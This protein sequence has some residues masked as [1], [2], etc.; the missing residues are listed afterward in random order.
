[1]SANQLRVSGR[2]TALEV[3]G[4][5]LSLSGTGLSRHVVL[6]FVSSGVGRN[7]GLDLGLA[8]IGAAMG[9][10]GVVDLGGVISEASETVRVS[11][12]FDLVRGVVAMMMICV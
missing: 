3:E 5:F 6:R 1:M 8:F 4:V 2:V 7:T 11:L 9:D 12:V 10:S